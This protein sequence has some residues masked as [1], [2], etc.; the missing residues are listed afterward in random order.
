[1]MKRFENFKITYLVDNF[2]DS[3]KIKIFM[4]VSLS[5]K[6]INLPFQVSV[7]NLIR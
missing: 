3:S 1:M 4:H 5:L 2:L 7:Y 6:D